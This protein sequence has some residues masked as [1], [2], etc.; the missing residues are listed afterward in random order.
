VHWEGDLIEVRRAFVRNRL[1]TT[2]NT[3]PR[4]VDMSEQLRRL[5]PRERR[6]EV[7][8]LDD[9]EPAGTPVA[10]TRQ[11]LPAAKKTKARQV[12]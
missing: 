5:L 3:K 11:P 1:T 6:N 10:P 8:C 9:V 4:R 2:K 12:A 7:N